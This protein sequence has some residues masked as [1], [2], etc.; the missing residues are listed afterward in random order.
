MKK[1]KFLSVLMLVVFMSS[2]S[3][4]QMLVHDPAQDEGNIL[5]TIR[6]AMDE[7]YQGLV[8]F[9]LKTQIAQLEKKYEKECEAVQ[10]AIK[11]YDTLS[12]MY[13][14]LEKT[15]SFAQRQIGT[16]QSIMSFLNSDFSD[17]STIR[18]L[19]NHSAN[20]LRNPELKVDSYFTTAADE[21]LGR[22]LCKP[23]AE[24]EANL[25]AYAEDL[26]KRCDESDEA[27][28]K[29]A[30]E[31]SL[32]D[33]GL[34]NLIKDGSGNVLNMLYGTY[35]AV[36]YLGQVTARMDA[37]QTA[38]N[39]M[40]AE[41]LKKEQAEKYLEQQ[42]NA[43]D[44]VVRETAEKFRRKNDSGFFSAFSHDEDIIDTILSAA[45]F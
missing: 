9:D 5:D 29:L 45:D 22:E 31:F 38:A 30:T 17:P 2:Q 6:N 43:M 39:R 21:I 40:M 42:E 28:E 3:F 20:R 36:S 25:R 34:K 19:I 13:G 10:W 23:S 37:N 33:K 12:E 8:Q 18:S 35:N 4:A 41:K 32:G 14:T 27:S 16:V 15:Y 1:S 24:A 11:Q 26:S 44:I 7:A